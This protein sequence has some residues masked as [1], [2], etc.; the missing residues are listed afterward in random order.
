MSKKALSFPIL[1]SLVIGNVIGTGIYILPASLAK[2]GVF[3][4]VSWILT[5]L[6]SLFLALTFVY[7]SK[8][9]PKTGGPYIYCQEAYGRLIGFIVAYAFW[10][11]YIVSVAAVAISSVG[12]L[13][14]ITP[15]LNANTF[16]YNPYLA[17]ALE[18]F[19]VWSLTLINI[20]SVRV[21]GIFQIILTVIKILPLIF[22]IIFGFSKIDLDNL[23]VLPKLEASPFFAISSA[24]TLTFWAFL[25]LE[26]ATI[27]A[28][29]TKSSKDIYRATFWGTG[30]AAIVYLLSTLVLLGML[31]AQKLGASQFP[32]AEASLLLVGSKSTLLLAF[33]AVISGLGTLNACILIQGQIIF[34]AARDNLFPKTF[35][36]L[37]KTDSPSKGLIFSSILA[38]IL[39]VFTMTPSLLEQFDTIALLA[40]FLFLVTYLI[41]ALAEVRFTQE[42]GLNTWNKSSLIALIAALYS[43]WMLSSF[44]LRIMGFGLVLILC[45]IPIYYL[46]LGKS[47][48]GN[49]E[50]G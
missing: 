30:I 36:R 8:R 41:S 50:P 6:G 25:G 3:S 14:F 23:L 1:M 19:F 32:F 2:Y 35:A 9:F 48:Y 31:P 18:L 37:S 40:T 17:L 43:L 5:S 22:I 28:E 29:S 49:V 44:E 7:L 10:A 20:L 33:L 38:S 45:C 26:S 21:A 39:L 42:S 47:Q 27:P 11:G 16:A 24:A 12:Y 4:L 15:L 13:G 46:S 34:A